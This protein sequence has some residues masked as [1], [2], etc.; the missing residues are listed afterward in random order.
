M[1]AGL[2]LASTSASRQAL[3]RG[4]GVDFEVVAP[5]VDED[6]IKLAML[7]T[8]E[9][10]RAMADAL[11]QAKAVKVSLRLP[12]MLVLGC[13]Q[14]LSYGAN[15]TLDKPRDMAEAR[16]HLMTLQGKDHKLIGAAVIALDGKPIWR[17]VDTATLT[18]RQL[19][20]AFIDWYLAT[21]GEAL[22]SSVGAYRLEALGSHLFSRIQGDYFTILGLPL[23]HLLQYLRDRK[24]VPS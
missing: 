10:P 1:S 22:L 2:V 16:Q 20:P 13:D 5:H 24:V 14:M 12:G 17:I 23:L 11:A 18:M 21:E 6:A 7:Q 3:L 19:G 15:L 9:T 8:G 4:A